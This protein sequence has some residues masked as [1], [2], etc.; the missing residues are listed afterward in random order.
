MLYLSILYKNFKSLK[1][2]N[3]K[4][5]IFILVKDYFDL[6]P[7]FFYFYH[8]ITEKPKHEELFYPFIFTYKHNCFLSN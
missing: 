4:H 8:S 2:E 6:V 1:K 5:K 7:T 3:S